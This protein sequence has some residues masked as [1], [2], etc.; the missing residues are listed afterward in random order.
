MP[1]LTDEELLAA[2]DIKV[3]SKPQ[4]SLTSLEDHVIAGFKEIQ[5]FYNEFNRVPINEE[6]RDILERLLSVRLQRI[7]QVNDYLFLLDPLDHQG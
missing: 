1:E 5:N 4:P 2:L 6:G 3:E 7:Q